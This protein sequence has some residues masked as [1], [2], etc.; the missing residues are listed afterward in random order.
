MKE[1]IKKKID[2][3]HDDLISSICESIKMPSVI[4]EATEG[5]PFGEEI[6]K[7]LRQVL[8]LCDSFGFKTVYKDGYY[9]YAEVGEGEELI[10]I[11]GHLDVVPEGEL[12]SWIHPPYE[13]VIE[14]GKLYGRGTQDDKGPTIACIYAVKALLDLGVKFDK[15]VRFI[16]GTDEENLWRDIAKYKENN[17]EIPNYGFTPDSKF[18]MIN[19]EKGL[20]QVYLSSENSSNI[21]LKCGGALNSVPD[22]AIYTGSKVDELKAELE[23]LGFEYTCEDGKV[24]VIGKGVH[25]AVSDTGKNAISRLC[26]ALYNIGE[27]SNTIDFISQ[28]IG[29]D[30]N[31]NNI[32]KDCKDDVSGKL[33]FN[34]GKLEL[35]K[36]KESL[37][38]DIRIPVTYKKEDVVDNLKEISSKH[39]LE[40]S[41]HDWL[42]SIYVPEDNFLVK[43]LRKVFEEETGLDST[44]LSS[45]GATY[46][47]ALDNCVAFG[48]VFPGKPKTEHQANE[49]IFVDDLMKATEI[50]ALS[51]YELLK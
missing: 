46:A 25:S 30:A 9:G 32:L 34:I 10:G 29:E 41:E 23:K 40:Y 39:N 19:A 33:T 49:Y 45:G 38:V 13:G 20:L 5:C 31:A 21:E 17:E 2:E 4:A 27:R 11:L 42:G 50:Y 14:D 24:C 44:P 47:R 3:L 48:S 6:D 16:F 8:K 15:R 1:E 26:I 37:G 7:S 22:K 12:E 35:T 36:E 43:S 18:P 28:V 51:V